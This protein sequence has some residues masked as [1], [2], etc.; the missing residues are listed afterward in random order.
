[1]F[2]NITVSPMLVMEIEVFNVYALHV[3]P[4]SVEYSKL[5]E[6]GLPCL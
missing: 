4:L 3:V 1:M 5:L 2:L 6:G